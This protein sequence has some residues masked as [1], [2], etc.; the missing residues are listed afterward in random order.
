MLINLIPKHELLQEAYIK[1]I[2]WQ[3]GII[4][5]EIKLRRIDP[6]KAI[7]I[8]QNIQIKLFKW[9][10]S[11][12]IKAKC[13]GAMKFWSEWY[14]E[15]QLR[16]PKCGVACKGIKSKGNPFITYKE[17]FLDG[18]KDRKKVT[19]RK[20]LKCYEKE[21]AQPKENNN[22]HYK[23]SNMNIRGKEQEERKEI[24]PIRWNIAAVKG[25]KIAVNSVVITIGMLKN[26]TNS[27][28]DKPNKFTK[29][30][31][32][33]I[34]I[35]EFRRKTWF[36]ILKLRIYYRLINI[37]KKEH[38]GIEHVCQMRYILNL[39]ATNQK[40]IY[41]NT[42]EYVKRFMKIDM[43]EEDIKEG[44]FDEVPNILF[45][46]KIP[47]LMFEYSKRLAKKISTYT[48]LSLAEFNYCTS[49]SNNTIEISQNHIIRNEKRSWMYVS[50]F[51]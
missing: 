1:R 21:D 37:K 40:I 28:K 47:Y 3:K 49:K 46:R 34:K 24:R 26:R 12:G 38:S 11:R 25:N 19:V 4:F 42:L 18:R 35:K 16:V 32:F 22:A 33:K 39:F 41:T 36:N 48:A 14:R 30:K 44:N 13:K 2:D 29:R 7:T 50:E 9:C 45:T 43:P 5:K 17:I 8:I 51:F 27:Y 6:T 23:E 20:K 15:M 10:I 31:K